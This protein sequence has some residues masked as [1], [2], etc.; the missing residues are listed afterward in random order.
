MKENS[1]RNGVKRSSF[2]RKKWENFSHVEL[3]WKSNFI[4]KKKLRGLCEWRN[5]REIIRK[6][7]FVRIRITLLGNIKVGQ[8]FDLIILIKKD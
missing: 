2:Q 7:N 8:K 5:L 1:N 4:F 3:I 6:I